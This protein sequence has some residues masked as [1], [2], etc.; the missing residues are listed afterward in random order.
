[1]AAFDYR[2]TDPWADPEGSADPLYTEQ[3]YRLSR[4]FLC[5]RPPSDT[6]DPAPLP[7]AAGEPFTFGSFNNFAKVSDTTVRMW[8]HILAR[9]PGSRLLLKNRALNEPEARQ[10]VIDR[11]A[12]H[13]ISPQRLLMAGLVASLH[14]HLDSYRV[15]DLALDTFPYA[16]TTT[17]FEALWM[18]VAVLTLPG[19]THASRTGLSI[20]SLLGLPSLIAANE[21]DY[22]DRAVSLATEG[23]TLFELRRELRERMRRSP[24]TDETGFARSIESAYRDMWKRWCLGQT[25]GPR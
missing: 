17:T 22:V 2:F 4:G 7:S 18:G 6:P 15:V 23:D 9:S 8:A 12:R 19:V 13:G 14:G 20:L 1:M 16:G 25:G 21:D 11:F 5:F 10:R 3:L 24:L